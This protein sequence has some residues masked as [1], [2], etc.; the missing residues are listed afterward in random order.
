MKYRQYFDRI[1]DGIRPE[2]RCGVCTDP[3]RD[4]GQPPYALGRAADDQLM[5]DEA[6]AFAVS[7][8]MRLPQWSRGLVGAAA[9]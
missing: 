6:E 2:A 7:N 5:T 8:L 4:A 9:D 3:E 1:I